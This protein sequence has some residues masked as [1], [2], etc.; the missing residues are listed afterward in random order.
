MALLNLEDAPLAELVDH[1]ILLNAGPE[2]SVAA[3]SHVSPPSP[4][5]ST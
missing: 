1:V 5:C 2:L 4:P 3:R